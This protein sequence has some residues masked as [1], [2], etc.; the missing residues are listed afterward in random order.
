[1][2]IKV[3]IGKLFMNKIGIFMAEKKN[4][5]HIKHL[6]IDPLKKGSQKAAK[7]DNIR[8][9]HKKKLLFIIPQKK[10]REKKRKRIIKK[11]KLNG[12]WSKI[13]INR[14]NNKKLLPIDTKY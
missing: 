12:T 14:L 13:F 2:V 4:I 1:V 10:K 6:S 11:S 3:N 9:Q 8:C 7:Y 5:S